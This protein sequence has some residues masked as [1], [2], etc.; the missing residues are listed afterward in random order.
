MQLTK[1]IGTPAPSPRGMG[2]PAAPPAPLP[3]VSRELFAVLV[4]AHEPHVRRM[5][6]R[7]G[8]HDADEADV[9]QE[10]FLALHRAVGRGLDV[11]VSLKGWLKRTTYRKAKDRRAL[12]RC[13]REELTPKGEI[14]A[15]DGRPNQEANM[16]ASDAQRIVLEL[17]DEL[18]DELR[19]VLVMSDADDMPMSEIAE[20]LEIPIGTGYSRLRAARRDFE[21][22]W[23]RRR[24]AQAPY[25]VAIG[26]APFLLFDATSL[27]A[28][29]RSIPDVAPD[30]Q[31]H[32][33]SR[34]V[35]ALGPGLQGAGAGAVVVGASAVAGAAATGVTAAK[36]AAVLL[37]A[38]QIAIGVA[39]SVGLGAALYAALRAG[40]DAPAPIAITRDIAPAAAALPSGLVSEIRAPLASATAT[41]ASPGT[42][43][44][45]PTVDDTSA[46]KAML[47]RARA[48]LGR[49]AQ[50]RDDRTRAREIA[51]SLAALSEYERRF[52]TPL[53][54][55]DREALK[56]QAL[57]LQQALP[58]QDGGQP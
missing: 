50:A 56:R 24:E 51:T 27:F 39:L 7:A 8:V 1:W 49:A 10:V 15:E 31:E 30:L 4:R 12:A 58:T 36:G 43:A 13:G 47:Q 17:L 26:I 32:A 35:D 37:T 2:S 16:V 42:D 5:A 14:D 57:L 25:G 21:A 40:H 20:V 52:K 54:G 34:L 55:D 44:G 19:L 11:S 48:A 23:N 38:K 33:W 3:P 9:V 53:F 18:P 45:A 22:A 28:A 46:E 6:R 41:A 29:E